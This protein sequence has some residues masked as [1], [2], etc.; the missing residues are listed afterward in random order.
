MVARD[1][2]FIAENRGHGLVVHALARQKDGL[3]LGALAALAAVHEVDGAAQYLLAGSGEHAVGVH[4]AHRLASALAN[5]VVEVALLGAGSEVTGVDIQASG[6]TAH[7]GG[8]AGD[9]E[10]SAEHHVAHVHARALI[11]D[12]ALVV[13]QFGSGS[14]QGVNGH[15]HAGM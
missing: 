12:V 11:E 8:K 9:G 5:D 3:L 14:A 10:L 7:V 15:V 6:V 4:V 2:V 13:Q 1:V